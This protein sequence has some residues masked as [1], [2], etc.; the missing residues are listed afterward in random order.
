[1]VRRVPV[2]LD[3]GSRW[4]RGDD[5]AG[6]IPCAAAYVIGPDIGWLRPLIGLAPARRGPRLLT[7]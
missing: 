1:M 4:P 3:D 5:G 7:T 2:G 6:R